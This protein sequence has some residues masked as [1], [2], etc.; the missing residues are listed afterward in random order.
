MFAVW[1]L[2]AVL[3]TASAQLLS[4][5][6]CSDGACSTSCTSWTTTSGSCSVCSGGSSSCS[7]LNPSSVT[8]RS[9]ITFYTDGA[10][11]PANAISAQYALN[12]DSACHVLNPS[13]LFYE[14][15]YV[16]KDVT[17][18]VI[19]GV[20]GG[21]GGIALIITAIV[22]C[23]R[24]RGVPCCVCC[25]GLPGQRGNGG[26]CSRTR[27]VGAPQ[28]EPP[29]GIVVSTGSVVALPTQ[30]YMIAGPGPKL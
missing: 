13:P 16:A 22:L 29:A 18:A 19:G 28:I 11:S 8:T 14:G 3:C 1:A 6:V 4:M 24:A 7:Y 12:F 9:G 2:T 26:C 17:G 25:C 27:M 10:C 30:P 23:C 15:S 5:K 20:I 21:I